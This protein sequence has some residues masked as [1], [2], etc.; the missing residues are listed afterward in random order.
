MAIVLATTDHIPGK[1]HEILGVV[2]GSTVRSKHV[3]HDFLAGLRNIVGGEVGSYTTLLREAREDAMSRL[4]KNA[5]EMNADAIVNI[6]FATSSVAAGSS[7]IL[8]YGTAVK[9]VS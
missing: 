8:A 9:F 7:E 6:R 1:E 4:V 5:E 2:E 3:G